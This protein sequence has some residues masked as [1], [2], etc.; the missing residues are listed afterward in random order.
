MAI[1]K[2]NIALDT[3]KEKKNQELN[4][5]C[6]QAILEGFLHNINGVDYWFSFDTEAQL[7]FQ[8]SKIVLDAGLI[9]VI[10]WTVRIGGKNGEYGRIPITKEIM[11]ELTVAILIHKDSNISKYREQLLP[12]LNAATTIEEVNA[13]TW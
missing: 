2:W 10:N 9:P 8:G 6:N 11:S 12:L 1:I 5:A 3:E 4:S 7:N 13:I